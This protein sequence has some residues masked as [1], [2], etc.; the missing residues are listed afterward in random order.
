MPPLPQPWPTY[1]NRTPG[2]RRRALYA[3]A[4][5]DLHPWD[6]WEHDG[7]PKEWTP[8]IVALL[9][10]VLA[11]SPDHPL[12]LHL[13]IH[14]V[15]ASDD[16]ARGD[17]AADRLRNLMPGMGHMV[18]MP[19]HIDVLRGRWQEAIEANTKAVAADAAYREAALVPPDFYRLYMSHNHHMKAYAAMMIG[20]QRGR[21]DIDPPTGRR[22]PDRLA[23]QNASGRT[24][25]LPCRTR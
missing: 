4:L 3:E 21:H 15:E 18:H 9:E 24:V 10:D 16:P 6:L 7:S 23:A 5:L 19:S 11:G 25:S 13:Y 14:T 17:E 2:R 22:N 20:P 12:A 8:E 1:M